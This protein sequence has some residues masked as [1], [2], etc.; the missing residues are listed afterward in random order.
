MSVIFVVVVVVLFFVPFKLYGPGCHVGS[1][2]PQVLVGEDLAGGASSK[3]CLL[4]TS[5]SPR[6]RW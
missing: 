2:S 4:Y 5:P 1:N 3:T 6:D